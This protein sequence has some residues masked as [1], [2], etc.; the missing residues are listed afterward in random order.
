MFFKTRKSKEIYNLIIAHRGLH[1]KYPENTYSAFK[2]AIKLSMAIETDIRITRDNILV[3]FHDRHLYRLLGIKGK[4]KKL[5]YSEL[6]KLYIKNS[7][8]KVPKLEDVLKLVDGRVVL[9]LE[10]KGSIN[11]KLKKELCRLL[12][13]YNGKVYFHTKNIFTY[14]YFRNIFTNRIFFIL[15][16]LRKRFKFIR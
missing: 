10:I 2:E 13:D 16:P 1:D 7:N 5:T 8:E 6:N 15:N 4:I 11:K 3:C 9:L 14:F 12:N